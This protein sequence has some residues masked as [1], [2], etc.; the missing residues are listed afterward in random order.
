MQ[1]PLRVWATA[2]VLLLA[3]ACH[4]TAQTVPLKI[5]DTNA[6]PVQRPKPFAPFRG[7][8][9]A[10]RYGANYT[11]FG[12]LDVHVTHKPIPKL[13]SEMLYW[14]FQNI[15]GTTKD[16]RDNVTYPR[17]AQQQ[18]AGRSSS[19]QQMHGRQ[20]PCIHNERGNPALP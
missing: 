7:F 20:P 13:T 9:D 12:A 4:S 10:Q 3:A 2:A 5:V 17:L 14:W 19:Q 15:E 11:L 1:R 8:K 16:P 6:L 18:E